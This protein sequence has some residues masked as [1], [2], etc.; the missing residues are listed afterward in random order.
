MTYTLRLWGDGRQSGSAMLCGKRGAGRHMLSSI[1]IRVKGQ[2]QLVTRPPL[3]A[4]VSLLFEG[5]NLPEQLEF[6]CKM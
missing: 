2:S 1:F 6:E 5:T 4:Y 3:A